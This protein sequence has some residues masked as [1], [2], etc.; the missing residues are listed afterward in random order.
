MSN[1]EPVSQEI[2]LTG[3]LPLLQGGDIPRNFLEY[4]PPLGISLS[5]LI[6]LSLKRA[7]TGLRNKFNMLQN[8]IT[9]CACYI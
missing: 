9:H 7:R 8:R 2:R 6:F 3:N 1:F 4:S 5:L